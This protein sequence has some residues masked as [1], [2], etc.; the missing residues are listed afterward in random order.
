LPKLGFDSKDFVGAVTSGE[1]AGH[2][3]RETYNR[4][5]KALFITWKTPKSP[6]PLHFIDLCG[7]VPIAENP[8]EADFIILHGVDVLRGPGP[9]G[10]A[11]ET[12]LGDF[13][14]DGN[15]ELL[16]PILQRCAEQN[17][18][19]VCANPDFTMVKPDGSTGHM[20]GKVAKRYEEMGGK[21]TSFG[22]P[23]R[24]HFEA[25][26]RDLNLPRD[27]VAHVG[28]SLHHDIAGAN[29][30]GIASV[31]VTGGIHREEL[32]AVLGTLPESAVL[33]KLFAKHSQTPTHVVAMFRF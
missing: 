20:P 6:S 5:E 27:R 11:K 23:Q 32:G 10:E 4:G 24:E 33:E 13:I 12:A 19:M 2:Y 22:K 3:I 29:D 8:D 28:D 21:V 25:C 15:M 31:F 17:L 16:E 9:D 18:P 30:T 1:E 14:Q 26:L 7:N